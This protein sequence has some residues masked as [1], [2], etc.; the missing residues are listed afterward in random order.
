MPRP[1]RRFFVDGLFL[2]AGPPA[3]VVIAA[4]IHAGM[5]DAAAL[6]WT[7]PHGP[8]TSAELA[9]LAAA[10]V[11][12]SVAEPTTRTEVLTSGPDAAG[13]LARAADRLASPGGPD[14]V[15]IAGVSADAAPADAPNAGDTRAVALVAVALT[16]GPVR[17]RTAA[18]A[19][20][21]AVLARDAADA[22]PADRFPLV[23]EAC[24]RAGVS[25]R[26]LTLLDVHTTPAVAE[27]DAA[28]VRAMLDTAAFALTRSANAPPRC[29]LG[30]VCGAADAFL[31]VGALARH[32]RALASRVLPPLTSAASVPEPFAASVAP[33]PWIDDTPRRSAVWHDGA[34]GLS[35]VIFEELPDAARIE[36][37][38]PTSPWRWDLVT[39]AAD[40]RESLAAALLRAPEAGTGSTPT[41][42]RRF[43]AALVVRDAAD[44]AAKAAR[45]AGVVRDASQRIY[46]TPDGLFFSDTAADA[47]ASPPS[48]VPPTR[49]RTAFL[50]PGQGSQY[51]GMF[52]DLCLDI[53]G[54]QGWFDGL[55]DS[56]LDH[57]AISPGLLVAP[58][59]LGLSPG[60]RAALDRAVAGLG[61]GALLTMTASLAVAD[62][63]RSAG[64]VPDALCGYSNGENAAL[65][66]G[67]PNLRREEALAFMR[68]IRLHD[69]NDDGHVR[70]AAL[71][72]NRA[73][74]PTITRV[75]EESGGA[76]TVALD[77]CPDQVVLFGDPASIERAAG[78]LTR[79]GAMCRK[80]SFEHGHHTPLFAGRARQL[81]AI[82]DDLD[83]SRIALPVYSCASAAPLPRDVVAARDMAAG[84]WARCVRFGDTVERM[85]ADGVRC[86]V[87]VGPGSTLTG[88]VRSTLKGRP[89]VAMPSNIAGRGAL[90]QL[91]HVAGRLFIHGHDV[92][93]APWR[94]SAPVPAATVSSPAPIAASA[95]ASVSAPAA[96][97]A[98]VS[99]RAADPVVAHFALMQEFLASQQRVLTQLSARLA[100]AA[101]AASL[102]P[103]RDMVG[104]LIQHEPDHWRFRR[105]F[106]RA[107]DL[108]LWHHTP[109]APRGR[110]GAVDTG[111]PIV[112]FAVSL[113]IAV[114]AAARAGGWNGAPLTVTAARAARWIAVADDGV[115]IEVDVQ[116]AGDAAR[117]RIFLADRAAAP[118]SGPAAPVFEATVA[119]GA[120]DLPTF[121]VPAQGTPM[122][123]LGDFSPHLFHGPFFATLTRYVAMDATAL[124]VECRMPDLTN[125]FSDAPAPREFTPTGVLD[126]ASQAV[127]LWLAERRHRVTRIFPVDWRRYVQ[128][129]P[130][131]PA[132]TTLVLDVRVAEHDRTAIADVNITTPDGRVFGRIDGLRGHLVEFGAFDA[133]I[134]APDT[135]APLSVAEPGGRR[136][137]PW[138]RDIL[139]DGAGLWPAVLAHQALGRDERRAWS[140]LPA[141]DRLAALRRAIVA[142]ETALAAAGAAGD[143]RHVTFGV[144]ADGSTHVTLPGGSTIPVAVTETADG[145][146]A[147]P[148]AASLQ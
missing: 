57:D 119:H 2:P 139:G 113:E 6:G 3:L 120:S 92:N 94:V 41:A 87:E 61:S 103:P 68:L 129:A 38:R 90:E 83:F 133:P 35:V 69:E 58:P 14:V 114:A 108:F 127:G 12:A 128:L 132:G 30:P 91:L 74:R 105:V 78:A 55:Q 117:V 122:L 101:G 116:R 62:L 99:H 72:V 64:V 148:L 134:F 29:A 32:A 54:V 18:L 84:Q 52:A 95:P 50:F 1:P 16:D 53:P 4:D 67:V 73:P 46:Q 97:S 15:V 137:P 98:P 86:F 71:A 104:E 109:G 28:R 8:R 96:A 100:P 42:G 147:A 89:H 77:N 49:G 145:L 82:Y 43:R 26:A 81:R 123:A 76:L 51:V 60:Q 65:M 21:R 121:P 110:H 10:L 124:R 130:P 34:A 20:V 31:G 135:D 125:W 33:R 146:H 47:G 24:A 11:A 48:G 79:A 141:G 107:R 56:M 85:Y 23:A 59:D 40:S 70:G 13:T 111:L 144:A 19:V 37:C 63:W 102:A 25:T 5:P 36:S 93:V 27:T 7:E 142:K 44:R 80:L 143:L 88:F 39:L 138:P 75:V 115:S 140:A 106:D 112:P 45:L 136:L 9:A 131:P 66:A 118:G 22:P 126:A 17:L